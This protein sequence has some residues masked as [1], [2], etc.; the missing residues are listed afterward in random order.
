MATDKSLY[1]LLNA[2]DEPGVAVVSAAKSAPA[3]TTDILIA[4]PN[5]P[6]APAPG[7]SQRV[8]TPHNRGSAESEP[9]VAPNAA[10]VSRVLAQTALHEE[11]GAAAD[12]TDQV[13]H[14]DLSAL[15]IDPHQPRQYF[16]ND[17]RAK[18]GAGQMSPSAAV[19]ELLQRAGQNNIEAL[20]YVGS[21]QALAKSIG[22]LRLQIPIKALPEVLDEQLIY[23][24][25]DGERRYW[26][27][28]YLSG[29][30]D[31]QRVGIWVPEEVPIII[32]DVVAD[33]SDE[34]S[35]I[36]WAVNFEREEVPSVDFAEMVWG[37]REAF[38]SRLKLDP[39]LNDELTIDVTKDMSLPEVA[40]MLA[41]REIERLTGRALARTQL[42]G[43]LKVGEKL[44]QDARALARAHGVSLNKLKG[45]C[46]LPLDRQVEQ[47]RQMIAQEKGLV[48]FLTKLEIQPDGAGRPTVLKR[49]ANLCANLMDGL[50]RLDDKRL[51]STTPEEMQTLLAQLEQTVAEIKR[52]MQSVQKRLKHV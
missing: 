47:M 9:P 1:D 51:S 28:I 50:R 14:V 8:P 19:M 3:S 21:V 11:Q 24:I 37:I 30:S 41:Q 29:L 38:V 25:V 49:S 31:N 20:G 39:T 26:A 40:N 10:A 45:I 17:L 16:P 32:S 6:N 12:Q 36:Q 35:R 5:L 34:V 15:R 4:P 18:V 13:I 48:Q 42:Y 2:Y 22:N 52:T 46:V 33:S 44:S 27:L 43:Y 23:R 7:E